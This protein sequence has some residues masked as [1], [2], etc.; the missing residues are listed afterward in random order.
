MEELFISP[1]YD[2]MFTAIFGDPGNIG[3]TRAFLKALLDIPGEDFRDLKVINPALPPLFNRGKKGIVDIR[4][5]AKS[6]RIIHIEMQ[7]KKSADLNSRVLFYA[8][9][10]LGDQLKEGDDYRKMR[11]VISIVICDHKL[12]ETDPSYMS[13]YELRS[14][15]NNLFT[16]LL[17]VV[18]LELP[19]LPRE[20]DSPAWPWLRFLKCKSLEECEMLA[21][22]HPEVEEAVSNTWKL[23]LGDRLRWMMFDRQIRK[24]DE[25]MFQRQMREEAMEEGH[26]IGHEKGREETLLAMA[27]KMKAMGESPEKIQTI[28]GLPAETIGEL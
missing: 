20:A 1:L 7:V 6:G 13:V 3:I 17:Q 22:K 21:K 8:A 2:R 10:L 15:K 12:A 9:R 14:R 4:L 18:I 19:K 24:M 26:A 28:T 23:S 11:Q 16:N 25:R 5:T 27:R